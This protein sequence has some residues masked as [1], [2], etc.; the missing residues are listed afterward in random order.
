MMNGSPAPTCL[1]HFILAGVTGWSLKHL[2]EHRSD[3]IP[4]VFSLLVFLLAYALLGLV[5]F[6][7][8]QPSLAMRKLYERFALLAR[9]CPLPFLNAQL[10]IEHHRPDRF[11]PD[12]LVP[13]CHKSNLGYAFLL[14]ALVAFV[15]GCIYS[16]LSQ[17]HLADRV[18]TVVLLLN[19]SALGLVSCDTE[20]YW[21][22]GLAVSFGT[23][24]F[25][26]PWLADRF[27]IPFVDLYTYGLIF[28]E[29]FT[30]NVVIEAQFAAAETVVR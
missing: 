20:N 25:A 21:G 28:Y 12:S 1:A 4:F 11:C 22:I 2:P 18:A 29:I 23:K 30:I 9:V 16:D 8:P 7:H 15:A 3:G 17:R 27:C 24:H 26:L 10:F 13:I 6:S 19:L 14:S 5:R